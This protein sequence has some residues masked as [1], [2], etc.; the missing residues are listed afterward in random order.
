MARFTG[1][2]ELRRGSSSNGTWT[3]EGGTLGTQPTFSSDPLFSG[4]YT[5]LDGVCRFSI[6]VDMDNITGFG[7]GQYFLKL[8]FVSKTNLLLSDG[9]LHDVSAGSQYAVLGHVD[10][11]SDILELYSISSNGRHVPFEHNVPVT[12]NAADNFHVAGTFQIQE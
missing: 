12:L 3:I 1:P 10:A 6:D 4:E 8:P 7:T 11:G 5:A 2:V 9:C